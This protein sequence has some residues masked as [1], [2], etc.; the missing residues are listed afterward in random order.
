MH[1]GAMACAPALGLA[2]LRHVLL[3]NTLAP[4]LT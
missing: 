3:N 4:T 2:N 1:M